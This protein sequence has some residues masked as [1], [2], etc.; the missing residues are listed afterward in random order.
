MESKKKLYIGVHIAGFFLAAFFIYVANNVYHSH[1]NKFLAMFFPINYS[2]WEQAKLYF[3]PTTLVAL[4]EFLIIGKYYKNFMVAHNIMTF[5]IPLI[6]IGTYSLVALLFPKLAELT[7]TGMVTGMVVLLIG[8]VL[9]YII[10][11]SRKRL[12]VYTRKSILLLVILQILFIIFT[13]V[14]PKWEYL[15]FCPVYK[16]YGLP[17]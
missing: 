13:F 17:F 11:S 16:L 7:Y 8:W 4:I 6:M 2:L 15:F 3:L 5:F 9:T 1:P 14:Q 12:F 10:C